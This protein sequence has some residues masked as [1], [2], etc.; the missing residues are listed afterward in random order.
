[1]TKFLFRKSKMS[2]SK[3][4]FSLIELSIVVLIIGILIAGV[5][6]G[7]RLVKMS[8]LK[9]AQSQ[10]QSSPVNSIANLVGWW[11]TTADT[12]FI[13]SQADDG[14]I[15]T[16]WYDN[17]SQT[18]NKNNATPATPA[19]VY[20]SNLIN[21][22][23][24]LAFTGA[25]SQGFVFSD[26]TMLNGSDYSIFVVE[27]RGPA[28]AKNYFL[29]GSATSLNTTWVNMVLGYST[30]ASNNLVWSYATATVATATNYLSGVT[31]PSVG[32]PTIHS[33]LHKVS[34]GATAKRY[35]LNGT[36]QA[37][38]TN[39]TNSLVS[40]AGG[41]IG[42]NL[43]A[44]P[45]GNY[46]GAIGE[47]IIYSKSLTTEERKAVEAYLGKKWAITVAL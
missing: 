28:V 31:A 6:Q 9:T 40:F 25:A 22:L 19:A 2:K 12:S 8:R 10:T 18:V 3:A 42:C 47:V 32:A 33:F 37:N 21:G 23:P 29:C 30:T 27:E 38:V 17:S 26:L 41:A 11:E 34:L 46:T 4:A 39:D 43:G 45:S 7:S 36:L 35:F 24:A 14:Q 5:T 13:D 15:P 20:R 1:M 44:S 16:I